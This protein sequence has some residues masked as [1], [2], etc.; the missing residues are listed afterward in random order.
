MVD[1]S[2]EECGRRSNTP[3]LVTRHSHMLHQFVHVDH[4]KY[5]CIA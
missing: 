5:L 2:D 1:G 3:N 4:V